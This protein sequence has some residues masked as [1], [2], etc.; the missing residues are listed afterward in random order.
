MHI[1]LN[2]FLQ[3]WNQLDPNYIDSSLLPPLF[4]F[5]MNSN[6]EKFVPNFGDYSSQ[7]GLNDSITKVYDVPKFSQIPRIPVLEHNE[8][9]EIQ[10][11]VNNLPR[12]LVYFG[13]TKQKMETK[14]VSDIFV[15]ITLNEFL[16][17]RNKSVPYYHDSS[18]FEKL[19]R[20]DKSSNVY[21][22]QYILYQ[23]VIGAGIGGTV[24]KSPS[25]ADTANG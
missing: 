18:W 15:H 14:N 8:Q 22:D 1:E 9:R 11:T 13:N 24:L 12:A 6:K 7:M 5:I 20:I 16:Q 23:K 4:H 2:Q 25:L 21:Y 19:I 3:E 17:W 10:V